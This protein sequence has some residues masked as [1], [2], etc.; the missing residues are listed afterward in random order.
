M[1]G[2]TQMR[3]LEAITELQWTILPHPPYSP[4]GLEN[5]YFGLKIMFTLCRLNRLYVL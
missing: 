4:L 2:H 1:R 5:I 3:T